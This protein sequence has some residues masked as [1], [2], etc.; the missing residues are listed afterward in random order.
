MVWGLIGWLGTV[1]GPVNG[2]TIGGTFGVPTVPGFSPNTNVLQALSNTHTDGYGELYREGT[3]AFLN[4]MAHARFP[5]TTTQVR[6]SFIAALSSNK[7]A[8]AQA[9]L[10]RLANEGRT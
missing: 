6:D 2:G 10:F 1:G 8:S 3:A 7:A 4:S 9:H 5:Y